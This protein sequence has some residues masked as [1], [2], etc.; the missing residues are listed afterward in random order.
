MTLYLNLTLPNYSCNSYLFLGR[1]KSSIEKICL[2]RFLL[3]NYS[4]KINAARCYVLFKSFLF[5]DIR[6]IIEIYF[7]IHKNKNEIATLC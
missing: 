2:R 3:P 5:P 7:T 6:G 1:R 4:A